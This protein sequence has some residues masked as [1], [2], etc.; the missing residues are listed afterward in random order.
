MKNFLKK[1]FNKQNL[2][3]I[4]LTEFIVK[5][6]ERKGKSPSAQQIQAITMMMKSGNINFNSV[7]KEACKLENIQLYEI[8]NKDGLLISCKLEDI[9]NGKINKESDIQG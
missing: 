4:E 1:Y 8:Y 3:D 9:K 6:S 2:T 7:C 5:F